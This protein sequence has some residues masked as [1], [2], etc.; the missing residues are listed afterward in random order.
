MA[1]SSDV[2]ECEL[3]RAYGARLPMS[4]HAALEQLHSLVNDFQGTSV[5]A[6][7][8]GLRQVG[9]EKC[10]TLLLYE[11]SSL[12]VRSNGKKRKESANNS[13]LQ[14]VCEATETV[15]VVQR[16]KEGCLRS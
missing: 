16:A 5:F 9:K 10:G 14:L 12:S 7:I 11:E 15:I 6:V 13:G 4:A 8:T 1:A 3:I 2:G